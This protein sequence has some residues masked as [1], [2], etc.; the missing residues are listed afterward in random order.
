MLKKTCKTQFLVV[1][2]QCPW[3]IGG[4]HGNLLKEI[5]FQLIFYHGS[6]VP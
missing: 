1:Y 6:I 4:R 2:I 5:Q 3:T